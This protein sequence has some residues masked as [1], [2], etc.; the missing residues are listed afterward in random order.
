[1]R[2]LVAVSEQYEDESQRRLMQGPRV[3][4]FRA[5]AGVFVVQ[6]VV[7]RGIGRLNVMPMAGEGARE[8]IRVAYSLAMLLEK[9]EWGGS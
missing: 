9:G 8:A 4:G 2:R 1:M 3:L 6:M 7:M 5:E